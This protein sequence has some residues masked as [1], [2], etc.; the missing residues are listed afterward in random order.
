MPA[1]L[2]PDEAWDTCEPADVGIDAGKLVRARQWLD[3][4]APENGYRFL[5]VRHGRV[6]AEWNSGIDAQAY[7][8]IAS[9]A[10]S[11]YSSVLGAAVERDVLA[12]ADERVVAHY[13]EMMDVPEGRGP[14]EGRYAFEKDREITFR[15]LISNTSGY[16]K[17]GEA[18]GEVFHYQT[19]GMNVLTHSL[20]KVHGRYDV[21]DPEGS[22]GFSTLIEEYLARPI[23]AEPRYTLSNF[24]LQPDARLDIFGYYCQ[25]HTR[26]VDFA[27][28]GWLWLNGGRWDGEQVVPEAWLREAT[29][30]APAILANSP[31]EDHRY[32][33]GFWT[34][35]NDRLWPGLPTSGF[36]ASGAG[37]H[38]CSVFPEQ[39]MVVVQNPGPYAGFDGRGN[40]ELLRLVL[41]AAE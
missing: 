10:K 9:A 12:S 37:G 15:Q 29:A 6:A 1:T 34:N 26:P 41:D 40:P 4:N 14:K 27:R 13:P 25:V 30:T 5:L 7:T 17:P 33:M 21:S 28:L 31:E 16:M 36:S 3:A 32:G 19:Y 20:A 35:D 38:Y 24:A 8:P 2:F 11:L 39:G 18:P 22:A 23:G